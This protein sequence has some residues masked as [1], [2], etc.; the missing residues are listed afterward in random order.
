[1]ASNSSTRVSFG[2]GKTNLSPLLFF[3]LCKM[4]MMIIIVPIST[5][6]FLGCV[7]AKLLQSCSIL[8]NPIYHNLLGSSVQGL[9][10]ARILGWVPMPFSRGSS[11]SISDIFC[12]DRWALYHQCHL[13]H[14][15]QQST[16]CITIT[17]KNYFENTCTWFSILM[18][19]TNCKVT[20]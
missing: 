4:G 10:Q 9:H 17:L 2:H 5:Y 11:Q 18:E 1:M 15:C 14:P 20:A 8:C 6:I 16:W 7:H 12:I 19:K 3:L 13:G